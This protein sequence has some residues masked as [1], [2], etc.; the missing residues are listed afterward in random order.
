MPTRRTLVPFLLTP[1]TRKEI[2]AHD[3]RW[4]LCVARVDSGVVTG[5]MRL[6]D[7]NAHT[8]VWTLFQ[9]REQYDACAAS[10]P[11]RFADPLMLV[12]E[13]Q[14]F[15]HAFDQ[16]HQGAACVR[17]GETDPGDGRTVGH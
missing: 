1:A 16:R 10:D 7:G 4:H 11:L 2:R 13:K 14:E 9:T 15:Q 5:R 6:G 17:D 3:G 12:Q 8:D